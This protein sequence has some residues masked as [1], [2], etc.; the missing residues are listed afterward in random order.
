MVSTRAVSAYADFGLC[1]RKWGNSELVE[2]VPIM[3]FLRN[4]FFSQ[5]TKM[6]TMW[7]RCIC[8]AQL[9]A[10]SNTLALSVSFSHMRVWE[11]YFF[12]KSQPLPFFLRVGFSKNMD[13][14]A[15]PFTYPTCYIF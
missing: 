9:L 5:K 8:N 13:G 1:T 15:S 12:T 3:P 11:K 14:S 4:M 2:S 6:L 7:N 10:K